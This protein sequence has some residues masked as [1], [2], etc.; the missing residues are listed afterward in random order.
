M[1][2]FQDDNLGISFV[3][4]SND[5]FNSGTQPNLFQAQIIPQGANP[6]FDCFGM[7]LVEDNPQLQQ[8]TFKDYMDLS[9]Q[10]LKNFPDP[11]LVVENLSTESTTIAGLEAE[12]ISYTMVKRFFIYYLESKI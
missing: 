10:N 12:K 4:G 7:V 3:Y 2:T 11:N 5:T 6:H 8:I 1:T 9:L